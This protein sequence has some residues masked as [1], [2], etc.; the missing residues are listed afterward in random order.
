MCNTPDIF[1]K[2]QIFLSKYNPNRNVE[3]A[4]SN[5]FA[6]ALKRNELYDFDSSES[7]KKEIRAFLR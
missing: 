2:K 7:R 5:S 6:T 3:E 1:L 4:L